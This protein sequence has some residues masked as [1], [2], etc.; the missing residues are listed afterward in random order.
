VDSA[1]NTIDTSGV[2]DCPNGGPGAYF[3][4]DRF[5]GGAQSPD[6]PPIVGGL[7]SNAAIHIPSGSILALDLHV[8]NASSKPLD[9]TV[10]TNFNTIPQSQATV[11]AGIYFFYNP[12]IRVPA[13]AKSQA[14]MSCPLTSNVTIVNAQSHM[15]KRGLG[16]VAN[17]EDSSG[18]VLQQLYTSSTWTDPPVKAWSPGMNLGAPQQ[19]DY[20]CNYDNPG[21][22]D[23]IQGLSAAKNEMCVYAGAYYPRDPNFESCNNPTYIGTG[24]ANG[25][26]TLACMAGANSQA[27]N[28]ED[29]YFGCVVDSCPKIAKQVTAVIT[30]AQQA[31][32]NVQTACSS[33]F[34]ALQQAACQ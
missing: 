31:G 29:V 34:T 30:C 16:A 9:V 26:T 32:Q 17:L 23:V 3:N 14:R 1:G 6:A 18:N 11:E 8:L 20:T 24:T 12:F 21:T 5:L 27:T 15:H 22:T 19:I 28:F 33:Q 13:G 4:V 7:P 10:V 25:A 2:W